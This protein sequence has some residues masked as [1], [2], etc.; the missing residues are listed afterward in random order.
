MNRFHLNKIQDVLKEY[1]EKQRVAGVNVLVFKDDKEICYF[2]EGYADIQKKRPFSRDT[3][4]RLFSMSK[5]VT[6]VAAMILVEQGKLDLAEEV[7]KYIPK[8]SN[9]KKC[10]AGE[11]IEKTSRNLLVQ[12]LLNMTSG[13]TYGAYGEGSTKGENLTSDLI[14]ELNNDV[15]KECSISTLQVAEKLADIPVNFEPGTDY[16]YG[17]S[18][19]ILGAVIEVV[20]G[21]RFGD[22]LKKNIF[23]PLEMKDTGFYIPNEKK[24]RFAQSYEEIPG[25]KMKLFTSPNLGIQPFMD[26]Q[27]SFESGG[28]G[29]VS[30]LD[31]YM[32]FVS[33]LINGGKLNEKRI[34]QEKT[35]EFMT[36]A[37]LKSDLQE[38]FDL[39][40]EHLLGYTYCNLLRI[41]TKKEICKVVTENGECGWDGWLGPYMSVD[42]KN[43]LGIVIMMQKV[44]S[45][46]WDLTRKIKNIIYTSL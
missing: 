18:A 30:T 6:A 10:T 34:L 43:N 8:F 41:A 37:K 40:M 2:E 24:S 25:Q 36:G 14:N 11:K 45:G 15:L 38:K 27:P 13:Y 29:L 35:V 16:Q 9:L 3:I 33:M 21:M 12:D 5:P 31:D 1:V 23:D 42:R 17:L 39:K 26:K 22:F 20:S 28:A 32:K 46:T 19:D 4:C 44:N 7:G